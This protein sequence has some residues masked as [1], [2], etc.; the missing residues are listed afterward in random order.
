MLR[1]L[2]QSLVGAALDDGRALTLRDL[3]RLLQ[4]LL[5]PVVLAE[6]ETIENIPDDETRWEVEVRGAKSLA[7][8]LRTMREQAAL[9]KTLAT[10]RTDVPLAEK[11]SDLRWRGARRELMETLCAELGASRL[12]EPVPAWRE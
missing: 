5:C 2:G 7:A 10:L 1:D 3:Q 6:Y 9:Y 8:N 12:M 4:R 11:L